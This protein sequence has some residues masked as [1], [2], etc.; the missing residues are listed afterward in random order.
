[1]RAET[2][3]LLEPAEP[4]AIAHLPADPVDLP[5]QQLLREAGIDVQ[6]AEA[7]ADAF[8]ANT[9]D[10]TDR[11]L[12]RHDTCAPSEAESINS[13]GTRHGIRAPYHRAKL[14]G[15]TRSKGDTYRMSKI[16]NWLVSIGAKLDPDWR[17]EIAALL[18]LLCRQVRLRFAEEG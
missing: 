5:E 1:M 8:I 18:N 13:I 3:L 12:L 6:V 14:L 10:E 15:I 9:L 11:V 2:D 17:E 7:S 4:D 16:G